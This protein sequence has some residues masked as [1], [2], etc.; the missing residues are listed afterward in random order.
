MLRVIINIFLIVFFSG[1][2]LGQKDKTYSDAIKQSEKELSYFLNKL[3]K[4]KNNLERKNYNDSLVF[5]LKTTLNNIEAFD[6]PFDSLESIF[7]GKSPDDEFRMFNWNVERDNGEHKYYCLILTKNGDVIELKDK[8]NSIINPEYKTLDQDNWYGA[9]YYKII[10]VKK[11]GTKYT[12]LAWDGNSRVTTKK[13]IDV[14]YFSGKKVK[15]G[16]TLFKTEKDTKRR[17]IFEYA[18][19]AY[20]SL[21]YYDNKKEQLIVFDHLM[22]STPQLEGFYQYYY[23]DMSQ[24]AFYFEGGKWVYKKDFDAR[25]KAS[26]KD[27]KYIDPKEKSKSEDRGIEINPKKQVPKK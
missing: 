20:M 25:N 6:Y 27:D 14:M 19:A 10:P 1:S 7:K 13:I 21:K 12:L 4:G 3:R 18:D 24:D 9:L 16:T 2:I 5:K 11:G 17:V 26:K 23:P 8:S 15:F 22:P